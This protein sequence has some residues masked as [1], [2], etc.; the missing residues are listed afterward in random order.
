MS[1]SNE[2]K[3]ETFIQGKKSGSFLE[4]NQELCELNKVYADYKI[5]SIRKNRFETDCVGNK[6]QLYKLIVEKDGIE[7]TLELGWEDS[8]SLA[9]YT[10]FHSLQFPDEI[11]LP[12]VVSFAW[13]K[14]EGPTLE[15]DWTLTQIG[16]EI[17]RN[18]HVDL[19]ILWNT[20]TQSFFV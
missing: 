18:I 15:R 1:T 8:F 14:A 2:N 11:H 19:K 20:K 3:D 13:I 17:K 5:T 10:I 4:I 12:R 7:S 6:I 16:W 9:S